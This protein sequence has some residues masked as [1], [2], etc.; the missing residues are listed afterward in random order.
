MI[1]YKL[2][3]VDKA[4]EY[5]NKALSINPYFHIIHAEVAENILKNIESKSLSAKNR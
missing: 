3:E 5:L 1:Y 4:K 2:G